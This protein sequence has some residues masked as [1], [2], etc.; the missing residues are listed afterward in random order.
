MG[1]PEQFGSTRCC[2]WWLIIQRI[3][4]SA[5]KRRASILRGILATR[6]GM[7]FLTSVNPEAHC[8]IIHEIR[9]YTTWASRN[10]GLQ[11]HEY[12]IHQSCTEKFHA[13]RCWIAADAAH[14]YPVW[15]S[16][17]DRLRD[18]GNYADW[19]G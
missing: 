1:I 11:L 14:L 5:T 9:C 18:T 16:R 7:P 10:R 13:C 6:R 3:Q 19:L 15:R 2:V 4:E 12:K 8:M 17:D